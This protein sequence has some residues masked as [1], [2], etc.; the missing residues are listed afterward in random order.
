MDLENMDP[1]VQSAMYGTP[2]INPDEQ[3]RYLGTFRERV[4]AAEYIKDMP[5]EA[6]HPIWR[7][8]LLAHPEA[9]LIM[10]GNLPMDELVPFMQLAKAT[11]VGFSMKNDDFYLVAPDRLG[12]VLAADEAVNI[13]AIN[14]ADMA[15]NADSAPVE[16]T[17]A[18][19]VPWFKKLF[20]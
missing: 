5:N 11:N 16:E 19:K 8:V 9:T 14:I 10:N 17:T 18:Q 15:S 2:K 7:E 3:R 13:D 4:Y 20:R 12:L 1:H 6:Y